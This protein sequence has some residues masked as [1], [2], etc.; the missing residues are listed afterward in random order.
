[1]Q[2][3]DER[4]RYSRASEQLPSKRAS[5]PAEPLT[6][7]PPQEQP[8]DGRRRHREQRAH[9]TGPGATLLITA[10]S[11]RG[12]ST[13]A[14]TTSAGSPRRTCA[15]LRARLTGLGKPAAVSH[16]KGPRPGRMH[17]VCR[18]STT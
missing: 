15:L 14:S 18:V 12:T 6:L 13:G 8:S 4:S 2:G 3:D 9:P 1:M 5:S 16:L 10:A 17:D 7:L 11:L